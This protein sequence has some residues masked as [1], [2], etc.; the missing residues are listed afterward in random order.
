MNDDKSSFSTKLTII[1]VI[2]LILAGGLYVKSYTSGIKTASGESKLSSKSSGQ[3]SY[4]SIKSVQ[5]KYNLLLP[6]IITEYDDSKDDNL[7]IEVT[8]NQAVEIT[9]S[10]FV[11][12]VLTFVNNNA[13]P[14][15][16]YDSSP[17][18][19]MYTVLNNE[20]G[21]KF[22]RYRAEYPEYEHCTLI[23]YCTDSMA[24]GILLGTIISEEE[25]L[26]YLN[27]NQ[28]SLT[29]TT[30]EANDE[31]YYTSLDTDSSEDSKVAETVTNTIPQDIQESTQVQYIEDDDYRYYTIDT[32]NYMV[33]IKIPNLESE[34][35]TVKT[36]KAASFYL[37]DNKVFTLHI[38]ST[39]DTDTISTSENEPSEQL[40][41]VIFISW[42]AT[43]PFSEGTQEYSDFNTIINTVIED[44]EEFINRI[45][46]S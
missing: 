31:A 6:D 37:G 4:N 29:A 11:V 38:N 21:I 10:Q 24:Y 20:N 14:L 39:T 34:I 17:V 43:N 44:K 12:K 5:S 19:N 32:D 26:N 2:L 22:F 7:N 9:T 27:I 46:T 8:M 36:Q 25:A 42:S 18:D 30:K 40:N 35:Q 28:S 45:K 16:L 23:N 33:Q 41:E 13:D 1:F 3:K 15:A